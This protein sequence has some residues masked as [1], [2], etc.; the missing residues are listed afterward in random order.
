MGIEDDATTNCGGV[1]CTNVKFTVS[2]DEPAVSTV[3]F[4]YALSTGLNPLATTAVD[5]TVPAASDSIAIGQS[6]VVITVPVL[7]DLLVEGTETFTI[8]LSSVTGSLDTNPLSSIVATGTILDNDSALPTD[9]DT[10]SISNTDENAGYNG[11][12]INGDG[13]LD[14]LQPNVGS[15]TSV[16]G[17]TSGIEV[18][19]ACQ[20]LGSLSTTNSETDSG[21]DYP[22]GLAAYTLSCAAPGQTA[23]I[24][25]Y[26]ETT[27]TTTDG[28]VLRK[29]NGT[30]YTTIPN[31]VFAFATIGGTNVLKA[32]YDVTDG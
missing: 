20:V 16:G 3:S 8:T 29:F 25:L 30:T 14:S 23:T 21:Y 7:T 12:D 1:A 22:E 9:N 11:G 13:I 4:N 28:I 5:Y 15:S 26:F 10:D 32:T 24:T 17:D 27:Q 2:L 31:P 19:G 18:T 6:S